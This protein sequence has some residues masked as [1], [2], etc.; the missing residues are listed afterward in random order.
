M[1]SNYFDSFYSYD[2]ICLPYD[3]ILLLKKRNII[4]SIIYTGIFLKDISTTRWYKL[5]HIILTRML[6]IFLMLK[7]LL[8][9]YQTEL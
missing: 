3:F 4:I 5:V 9:G 8:W 1:Q 6:E 2:F 7:G